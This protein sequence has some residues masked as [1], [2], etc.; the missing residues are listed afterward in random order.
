MPTMRKEKLVPFCLLV[1]LSR[2]IQ[3]VF[4]VAVR[5][6]ATKEI[7]SWQFYWYK[8][9]CSAL[10]ENIS[11]YFCKIILHSFMQMLY[12]I[13]H[14]FELLHIGR[15]WWIQNHSFIFLVQD[16]TQWVPKCDY[17]SKKTKKK[18]KAKKERKKEKEKKL[19]RKWISCANN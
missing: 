10:H 1:V 3:Y 4:W 12:I 2:I 9:T 11:L 7:F 14:I 5:Y 8:H 16:I 13:E 19:E 6:S 18:K 17:S 15:K